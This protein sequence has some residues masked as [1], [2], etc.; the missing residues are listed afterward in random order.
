MAMSRSPSLHPGSRFELAVSALFEPDGVAA[1]RRHDRGRRPVHWE[2]STQRLAAF[3]ELVSWSIDD[4]LAAHRGDATAWFESL[5][6]RHLTAD[7]S[8]VAARRLYD[9]GTSIYL[10]Q[11]GALAALGEALAAALA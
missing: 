3:E 9:G 7:L 11:V 4:V 10:K 5:T 8:P 2:P 6:G 1:F